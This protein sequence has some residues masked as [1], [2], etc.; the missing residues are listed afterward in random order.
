[1][2]K[3]IFK[4][5][6]QIDS[7]SGK[8]G[9]VRKFIINFC[10]KRNIRLQQDK[11]G[12]LFYSNK[13]TNLILTAHMDTVQGDMHVEPIIEKGIFKSKG[14]T[15]LGADDKANLSCILAQ[16]DRYNEEK[17]ALDFELLF[18]VEEELGM[19][20]MRNFNVSNL[21]SKY[22]VSFDKS[23][24][25]FGKIVMQAPFG[26]KVRLEIIG[27]AAHS[28]LPENA[29]NAL[30]VAAEII[31]KLPIGG[32]NNQTT[33][34]FGL[35]SGGTSANT[36]P[37]NVEFSGDMRGHNDEELREMQKNIENICEKTTKN[38]S[39]KFKLD[40][41]KVIDGYKIEKDDGF[42]RLVQ[43][44]LKNLKYSA[45]TIKTSGGSDASILDQKGIKTILISSGATNC[46]TSDEQISVKDLKDIF[47]TQREILDNA[48]ILKNN[49]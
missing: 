39:A 30:A 31:T 41:E 40:F 11:Y 4:Q 16:V 28:A 19:Q 23:E 15:I 25:E 29:V 46:H 14:N 6:V 5:L 20:G 17:Q 24:D 21:Y 34:N 3:K 13:D 45:K 44:S 43:K 48:Y 12:N 35:V 49:L 10:K 37:E 26:Y 38:Y 18:T 22:A 33:L 42:F 27:K 8:E 47:E 9:K 1:M 2:Y 32:K 7:P 36:Y